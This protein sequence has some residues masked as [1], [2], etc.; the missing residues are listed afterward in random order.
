M[1]PSERLDK[2]NQSVVSFSHATPFVRSM[3][4][5][6]ALGIETPETFATNSKWIYSKAVLAKASDKVLAEIAEDLG[7]GGSL[8]AVVARADRRLAGVQGLGARRVGSA[9]LG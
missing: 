8:A 4:T 3:T 5:W 1:K 6:G 2:L 7:L 9:E